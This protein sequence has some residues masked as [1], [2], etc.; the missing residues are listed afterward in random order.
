MSKLSRTLFEDRE[1]VQDLHLEVQER[2]RANSLDAQYL[3]SFF[4][5]LY[6]IA[7][8]EGFDDG[9]NSA[10][11]ISKCSGETIQD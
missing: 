9:Q 6:S 2:A 7:Y 5:R 3:E 1:K 11:R 8:N 4:N 10:E